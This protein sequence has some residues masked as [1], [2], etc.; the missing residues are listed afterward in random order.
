MSNSCLYNESRKLAFIADYRKRLNIRN[1][2]SRSRAR[3]EPREINESS[4]NRRENSARNVFLSTLKYETQL[5]K[6]LS[7]FTRDELE[8]TLAEFVEN[9]SYATIRNKYS[10]IKFYFIW[11]Y[12]KG[13]IDLSQMNMARDFFEQDKCNSEYGS[14]IEKKIKRVSKANTK[15][16]SFFVFKDENEF[17]DY[18]LAVFGTGGSITY[19]VMAILLYYGFSKEEIA[20]ILKTDVD[21]QSHSVKDVIIRN[22]RLFSFLVSYKESD[23]FVCDVVRVRNG[24]IESFVSRCTYVDSPYLVR[25]H[26]RKQRENQLQIF[27]SDFEHLVEIE[28]KAIQNLPDTFEYKDIKMSANDILRLG[29]FHQAFEDEKENGEEWL[30]GA[31]TQGKYARKSLLFNFYDYKTIKGQM[32]LV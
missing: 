7:Y 5:D 30:I 14:L 11:C 22:E 25:K 13:Y 19:G 8:W 26:I 2:S 17:A 16:N 23:G 24:K 29:A 12:N 32:R 4:E 10:V 15:I 1:P 20:N 3:N 21:E 18:V 6:D 28:N 9:C 27:I 31:F